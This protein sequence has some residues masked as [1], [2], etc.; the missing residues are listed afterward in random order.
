M[1]SVEQI[2][3]ALKINKEKAFEALPAVA[4]IIEEAELIDYVTE[5]LAKNNNRLG[6][7]EGFK[8]AV[9]VTSRMKK[10]P[11]EVDEV[12]TIMFDVDAK[13][14]SGTEKMQ[15]LQKIIAEKD[16]AEFF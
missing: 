8:I 7:K 5:L 12:L 13:S 9:R 2:S 14:L 4:V 10:Y 6:Q 1:I 16:I 3:K 15:L 11:A